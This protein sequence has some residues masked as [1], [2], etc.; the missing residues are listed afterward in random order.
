MDDESQVSKDSIDEKEYS[1]QASIRRKKLLVLKENRK[2]PFS[3]TKYNQTHHSLEIKTNFDTLEG[4]VVSIAGRLMSFREMG[5]A[6]FFDIQDGK[7]TIQ[8]YISINDVGALVYDEVKE[9]DIGDIV[10]VEGKVFKTRRNEISVHTQSI[11]LLAKSIEPLPEKYHGLKDTEL[12]YRR[13]YLDLIMNQNT[14]NIFLKRTKIISSIRSYLDTRDFIEV[15]TPILSTIASGAAARPFITK[16][17]AL[18]LQLYLRIATELYLKRCIVGGMERVYDM[19]KDFRNEG[20]DVRHSP[21]FTMIELYQAFSDYNDMMKL[22][23]ELISDVTVKIAGTTKITYQGTEI[24]FAPPWNRITMIDA[25]RNYGQIDF[26]LVHNDEEA[27]DIAI[28]F[29]FKDELKKDINNCTYGDILNAAFEKYVEDKLIQPTFITDYPTDIS[30][31]TKQMPGNPAMTERFEAFVYGSEIAN[32]Y[33]ELNDPIVQLDRFNQQIKEREMGDE[34]AYQLDEDFISSLEIGMPPTG[35]MGIGIDRLVMFL[36]D[37]YSIRD[38]I[39][40]PIMKP[41][42]KI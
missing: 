12:R 33:S 5:K 24:Q 11:V 34:E 18:N 42:N 25:I 15:E 31:L 36:T 26:S 35:G 4:S 1:E 14:R 40:F 20:M 39:L 3:L 9:Y 10:G 8:V 37:A 28:K 7:G 16:S 13:R 23:E 38:V 29:D 27:R 2:N 32:A 22:C 19:G 6:S 30:P 21:E 17:N 41:D